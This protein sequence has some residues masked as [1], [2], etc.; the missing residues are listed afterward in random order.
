[1][2]ASRNGN[3]VCPAAQAA[4]RAASGSRGR[5]PSIA[6]NWQSRLDRRLILQLLH[7][8]VAPGQPDCETTRATRPSRRPDAPPAA[9]RSPA[10]PRAA[11]ALPSARCGDS[12]EQAR[13]PVSGR[14]HRGP[15]GFSP[16]AQEAVQ[17]QQRPAPARPP[18]GARSGP[19]PA[20]AP[21]PCGISPGSTPGTACKPGAASSGAVMN[22]SR[23]RPDVPR[24]GRRPTA[25][26]RS[27]PPRRARAQ[28]ATRRSRA[29]VHRLPV[30]SWLT[31]R[32]IPCRLHRPASTV[33]ASPTRTTSGAPM[34][35]QR[36][37]QI[38]QALGHELPLPGRGVGQPPKLRFDDV[39]R[40]DRPNP[41]RKGQRRVVLE[42]QVA[43]EPD[44]NIHGTPMPRPARLRETAPLAPA[45]PPDS[46]ATKG[47]PHV[48]PETIH[49]ADYLAP[50]HLVESV[51]L[52]FRL[53]PRATR[54]LSR[55]RFRAP[56]PR[57]PTCGWTAKG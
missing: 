14:R 52:T 22:A 35:R 6:R 2:Q 19:R 42:A 24:G 8:M 12:R 43:L 3:P 15:V 36:V 32:P 49:L 45:R 21:G 33:T 56:A 17:Q 50:S 9:R 30:S 41:G 57:P 46:L 55:I 20:A 29:K 31:I 44:E 7:E 23:L 34:R 37:A 53:D 26:P 40:Q 16:H 11:T 39:D 38:G 48:R 51:D 54:V 5:S 1:M 18:A 4:S 10:P 13:S 27:T 28:A 47:A 25:A